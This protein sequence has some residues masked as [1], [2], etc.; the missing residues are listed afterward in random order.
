MWYGVAQWLGVRQDRILDVLP[1][2]VHFRVNS[3]LLQRRNCTST[4]EQL[5]E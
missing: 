3:T 4:S 1:G 5:Y 2:A